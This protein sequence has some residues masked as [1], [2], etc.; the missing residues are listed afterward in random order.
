MD[1]GTESN[2]MDELK[3][4]HTKYFADAFEIPGYSSKTA[5]GRPIFGGITV[6][7]HFKKFYFELN[8]MSFS[9]QNQAVST[10]IQFLGLFQMKIG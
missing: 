8:F 3:F 10:A 1:F 5:F 6:Y 7:A 4:Q 9:D 2:A